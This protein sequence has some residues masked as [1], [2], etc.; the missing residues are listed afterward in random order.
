MKDTNNELI[1]NYLDRN[2]RFT[3]STFDNYTL[4]DRITNEPYRI[5]VITKDIIKVFDIKE[6]VLADI[7]GNWMSSM[8]IE[9]NNRITDI[10]TKVYIETGIDIQ[11]EITPEEDYM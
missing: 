10:R 4:V 2:Y 1:S 3:L 11:A 8:A 7:I 6:D 9:F 5:N